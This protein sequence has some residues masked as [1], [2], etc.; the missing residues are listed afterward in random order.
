MCRCVAA[1][2]ALGG[3]LSGPAH[4]SK[5]DDAAC[6]TLKAEKARLETD[7]LK[8][9]MAKG[10][11]WAKDNLAPDRLKEIEQLIGLQENIAFR[12]ALPKPTPSQAAAAKAA[13]EAKKAATGSS[14]AAVDAVGEAAPLP[15]AVNDPAAV[16][17]KT[18]KS[19]KATTSGAAGKA[20]ETPSA[21]AE[22]PPPPK[23]PVVQKSKPKVSDAYAPPP[24]VPGLSLGSSA[25]TVPGAALSP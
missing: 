22:R 18:K 17:A 12:C 16:P 20:V 4:A 8:S 14:Q 24:G 2:L 19:K 10:P 23:P 7:A 9:D 13:K 5:L 6:G 11:Q 21:K 3:C 1:I 15:P 25:A